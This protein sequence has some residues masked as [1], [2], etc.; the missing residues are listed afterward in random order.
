M[1]PLRLLALDTAAVPATDAGGVA[2]VRALA[3]RARCRGVLLGPSWPTTAQA[4]AM[5]RAGLVLAAQRT[6]E[7]LAQSGAL[8]VVAE[9]AASGPL[10]LVVAGGRSRDTLRRALEGLARLR[11][12]TLRLALVSVPVC[13]RGD[14]RGDVGVEVVAH[15]SARA[16]LAG[17][18][19]VA[20]AA[21]CDACGVRAACAGPVAEAAVAPQ[22]A[23]VSNQFDL[24]LAREPS[25]GEVALSSAEAAR[26]AWIATPSGGALA[27][28]D[29]AGWTDADLHLV[30]DQLGQLWLDTSDKA[31]LDDFAADLRPLIQDA[32]A[33]ELPTGGVAPA[34]WRPTTG[35][36]F[37]V[38]EAYVEAALI[39]M[40][41]T[42]VDI[43][44][45]PVRYL[46]LLAGRIASGEVR[47]A[48]VE[49]DTPALRR[50]GDALPGARLARGVGE[51]LP[52]RDAVADHVLML[53]SFNH[54]R[55]VAAAFAEASRVA[56]DGASLLV[57]D[58]VAFGLVRTSAQIDR[59]RA[60]SVLETP[61]EHYRNANADAAV[62]AIEATGC[63]RVTE[64]RA[65]APGR[66]NQWTVRARRRPREPG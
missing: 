14:T 63:W 60:V 39:A 2:R 65:V 37:A 51:H 41:G 10:L 35:D 17:V 26:C 52:V 21:Q 32:P 30:L 44:A 49:P 27:R 46:R 23:P 36:P 55:D 47:Y 8:A 29:N 64:V 19:E 13:H 53:R 34:R 25:P 16:W 28:C 3:R 5:R 11:A 58:N 33:R 48:A 56:A 59:A 22:P 45:G 31:R 40:R 66:A 1:T 18:A 54:L 7:E 12:P 57:V 42:V 50:S 24:V 38:E 9:L 4:A 15:R 62:A 43:G 6:P 61:F 20:W